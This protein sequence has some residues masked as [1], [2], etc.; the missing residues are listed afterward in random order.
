MLILIIW[1]FV[2]IVFGLGL[3]LNIQKLASAS[4]SRFWPRLTSLDGSHD[5][6]TSLDR[7]VANELHYIACNPALK[8]FVVSSRHSITGLETNASTTSFG[9]WSTHCNE[10]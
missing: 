1:Y 9:R 8:S 2:I 5:I 6:E 4:A 10:D 7:R 3:G